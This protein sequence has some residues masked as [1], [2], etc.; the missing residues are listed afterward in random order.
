MSEGHIEEHPEEE[1]AGNVEAPPAA[2]SA[3]Q[4]RSYGIA[5]WLTTLLILVL[6][7]VALSPFWA[8]QVALLLPWGIPNDEYAALAGRV[9]AIEQRSPVPGV[10]VDASKSAMNELRQRVE[11]LETTLNGRI[12][13]SAEDVDALKSQ[14][15][16][17]IQQVGRL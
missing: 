10:D 17:L 8:P 9:S 16:S 14:V 11:Q 5:P 4:R 13:K 7:G 3:R 15:G 6:A 2:A 12:A 1:G